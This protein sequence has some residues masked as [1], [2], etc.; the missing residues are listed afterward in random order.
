MFITKRG[1][2]GLPPSA[3]LYL[4]I[5]CFKSISS[6]RLELVIKSSKVIFLARMMME[7]GQ[8]PKRLK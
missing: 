7:L 4:E 8:V 5:K 1:S 6:I 2:T 3:V